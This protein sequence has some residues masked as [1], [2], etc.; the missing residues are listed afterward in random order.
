M[1]RPHK[2]I[3]K[4]EFEKLCEIQ[5][6]ERE[7]C[8][9]FEIT[10]KTLNSWCK[11]TYKAG[12]S[13]VFAQKRGGGKV[14]LRRAQWRKAVEDCDTTMLIWLGKQHLDQREPKEQKTVELAGKVGVDAAVS[15]TPD[16]SG[17]S[18][19]ELTQFEQL[20]GKIK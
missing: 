12:F 19:E 10:D 11:R 7:I 9:F 13:E 1:A 14:S 18:D 6:T 2:L 16:L 17:L 15:V 8:N 5:C 20:F 3:D 4:T